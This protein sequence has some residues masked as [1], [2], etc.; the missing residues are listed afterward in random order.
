MSAA[1]TNQRG[2]G[3]LAV[4][5]RPLSV[6]MPRAGVLFTAFEPSGDDHAS[7]VIAR[8]RARNPYLPIYAW[9][10]PKMEAAGA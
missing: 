8:L 3:G 6:S 7:V 4:A 1:A 9:G 5:S 2:M 10:G